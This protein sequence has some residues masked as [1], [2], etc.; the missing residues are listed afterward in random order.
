[1]YCDGLSAHGHTDWY[2]PALDELNLYWNGG[3]GN[4]IGDI[5][6][7]GTFYLSSTEVNFVN[8]W[9]QRFSDGL[10]GNGSSKLMV[11]AVRCARK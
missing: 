11:R 6:I 1:M 10:Q 7:D 8:A 5:K 4:Q 2:L 9:I 3:G